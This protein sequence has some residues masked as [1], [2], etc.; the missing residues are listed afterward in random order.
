MHWQGGVLGQGAN[1]LSHRGA[2]ESGQ[3]K[4]HNARAAEGKPKAELAW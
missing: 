1:V 4:A 2:R 3:G